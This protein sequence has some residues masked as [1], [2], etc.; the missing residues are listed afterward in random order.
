M[1]Y[2]NALLYTLMASNFVGQTFTNFTSAD[3]LVDDNVTCGTYQG[4]GILWFGTQNGIS[5]FDGV[6]WTNFTTSTDS[7]LISNT[8]TAIKTTN[9]GDLWVGTDF[10]VCKYADSIWTC[11]TTADG[12]GDDLSLIHI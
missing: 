5:K 1:K 3:G 2:L 4:N 8:I 6:N 9:N 10:G 12:L 7:N 11:F